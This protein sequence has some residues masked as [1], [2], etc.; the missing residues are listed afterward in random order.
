MEQSRQISHII[1]HLKHMKSYP[2]EYNNL[3]DFISRLDKLFE[4]YLIQD[5]RHIEPNSE[6]EGPNA[7]EEPN[8]EDESEEESNK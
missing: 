3:E 7:G 2:E 5:L 1:E 6:K 4:I 8:Y